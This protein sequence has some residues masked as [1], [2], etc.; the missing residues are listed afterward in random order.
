MNKITE[1]QRLR[2]NRFLLLFLLVITLPIGRLEMQLIKSMGVI[3]NEIISLGISILGIALFSGFFFQL[4]VSVT[5]APNHIS[6][7][8]K[9]I[10]RKT[11]KIAVN[12]ITSWEIVN[13]PFFQTLGIYTNFQGDW[14]FTMMPGKALLLK[15]RDG[16]SF[17]FGINDPEKVLRFIKTHWEQ[18]EVS[19][20]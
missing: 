17:K 9:P 13:H 6:Y 2:S 7:S 3:N 14:S 16:R 11:R 15:T 4:S 5:Y 19:Y 12:D 8:F 18:K 20:G 10:L 1:I